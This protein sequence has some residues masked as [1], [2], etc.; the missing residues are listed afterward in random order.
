M[1]IHEILAQTNTDYRPL[2]DLLSKSGLSVRPKPQLSD[3]LPGNPG[4]HIRVDNP[5]EKIQNVAVK[6][7]A[8]VNFTPRICTGI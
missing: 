8:Q 3:L 1:Q 4:R 7:G 2:Q 5:I 6:L